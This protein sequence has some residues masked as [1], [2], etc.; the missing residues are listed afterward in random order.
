M[1][2]KQIEDI[3]LGYEP[4][5]KGGKKMF[6]NEFGFYWEYE[7]IREASE[8]IAN[9]LKAE[10]EKAVEEE[11]FRITR[12]IEN[13]MP[14]YELARD[15]YKENHKSKTFRLGELCGQ[16]GELMRLYLEINLK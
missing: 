11:R 6:N 2:N 1:M 4:V 9:L 15:D 13:K 8:K 3:L 12:I 14:A 16:L 7:D 5:S 10:R